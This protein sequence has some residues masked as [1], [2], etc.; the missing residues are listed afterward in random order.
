MP[1]QLVISLGNG[2]DGSITVV[3]DEP[4]LPYQRPPL[5]KAFLSGDSGEQLHCAAYEKLDAVLNS[6]SA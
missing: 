2:W 3:S 4:H 6:A 1:V 5:S